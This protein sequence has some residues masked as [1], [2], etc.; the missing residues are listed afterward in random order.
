[1]D[2]NLSSPLP[3]QYRNAVVAIGN[4]DAIHRGHQM[5]LAQAR[6][7]ATSLQTSLIVLTFEPHPR[8]LFRPDDLPFRVT[9]L[10]VK[11]ERLREFG[12][13]AVAVL[14]FDWDVAQ[15]SAGDFMQLILRDA[16]GARGI[17]VGHDFHFA[18]NRTGNVDMLRSCGFDVQAPALFIDERHGVISATRVRGLLQ[19]GAIKEA[20][21]LLGWPWEIRGEVGHGD[22][23]GRTIGYPTANVALGETIHPAYGVYATWVRVEGDEM[24]M[25]AATNIGIRPMFEVQI[26][27]VEAYLLDFTGDLYGK[28]LHIRPVQKIRDEM[29]FASLDLL[30][31][32]I[33]QDCAAV[34]MILVE[35]VC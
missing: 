13:D 7:W 4:F 23:R 2:F 31:A 18:H 1:M 28:T 22:K 12:V 19:A 35:N 29:K 25:K 15:Q 5:L 8:R 21:D 3:L 20:N 6:A 33:E 27:L 9:P 32:Q 14:P 11:C 17:V 10:A 34:R 16:L 24:W 30:V 26:G